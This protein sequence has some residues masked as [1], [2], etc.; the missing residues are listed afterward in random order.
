MSGMIVELQPEHIS[1]VAEVQLLAWR[2]TYREIL[3]EALLSELKV[4][5]FE[6]NWKAMLTN[7]LRRNY[8]WVDGNN[9]AAGFIS[10]GPPRA[11]TA[12][13][14]FEIYGIYVHPAYWNRGIGFQ[15][16]QH[17]LALLQEE[18]PSVRVLPWTM[19]A[20]EGSRRFYEKCGFRTNGQRRVATRY[21]SAFEEVQYVFEM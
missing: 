8:V 14:N 7:P 16:M 1:D 20:N 6:S 18:S 17:V 12:Q 3:G 11:G 2:E 21:Q 5:A 13:A 10:Y 15:L 9:Q 19:A 4:A